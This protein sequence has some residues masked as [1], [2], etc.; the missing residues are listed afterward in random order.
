MRIL[1]S[2]LYPVPA[3]LKVQPGIDRKRAIPGF[4]LD[5]SEVCGIDVHGGVGP[6]RV[7]QDIDGVYPQLE[8]FALGDFE[9][10]DQIHVQS[11]AGGPGNPAFAERAELSGFR[12]HENQITVSVPNGQVRTQR[13]QALRSGD[14]A[15]TWIRPGN[16]SLKVSCA[17]DV[18]GGH[19]LS[20][21]LGK[22]TDKIRHV[23]GRRTE[24][25]QVCRNVQ[26]RARSPVADRAKLPTLDH[27]RQPA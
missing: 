1:R 21:V 14:S 18:G 16:Q 8:F 7:V 26:R 12:I 20:K 9:A 11:E 15:A 13:V 6:N 5:A 19:H 24:R 10:L 22:C 2:P 17:R 23:G 27:A 4:V 25:C 3:F